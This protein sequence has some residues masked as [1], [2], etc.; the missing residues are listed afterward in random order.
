MQCNKKGKRKSDA[1][2]NTELTVIDERSILDK[3]M[4]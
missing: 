1:K 3:I 4:K 2:P